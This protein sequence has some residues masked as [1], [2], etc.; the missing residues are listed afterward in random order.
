MTD[1]QH[2]DD[3]KRARI[4]KPIDSARSIAI[5]AAEKTAQAIEGNPMSVIV[6][7]LAVGVIA[8]AMLPHG[9]REGDLL[10][11]IGS[12]LKD[13]AKMALRAARDAGMAE[14]AA[15]GI[16]RDAA[17]QQVSKLIDA[18]SQAA[19][20]AG[21][22]AAKGARSEP[23]PVSDDDSTPAPKKSAK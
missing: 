4:A 15:A 18:V 5:D 6:G 20:R 7:G 9:E 8:G 17:R 21:D 22:A 13:G 14:L 2:G 10:R 11:P 19:A 3:G 23:K 16:S 12:R 1:N